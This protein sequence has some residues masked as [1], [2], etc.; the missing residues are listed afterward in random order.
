MEGWIK[1][2]RQILE[3]EWYTDSNTFRLFLHLLLKANVVDKNWRGILILRGQLFTSVKSL[4]TELKLTD[5]QI[6]ISLSKLENTKELAIKGASNGTMIT[7]CKYELYQENIKQKGKQI[8]KQGANEGQQ[9]KNDKEVKE[10]FSDQIQK[11][12]LWIEKNAPNVLRVEHQITDEQLTELKKTHSGEKIRD[13]LLRMHNWKDTA[14]K[15]TSVYL[16]LLAWSRKDD[17]KERE[18]KI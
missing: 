15:N 10:V 16:T 18:N 14:K 1:L 12:N 3:W 8:G 9:H 7:V 6:R 11:L 17:K 2:F 13:Y 4:S 5:K